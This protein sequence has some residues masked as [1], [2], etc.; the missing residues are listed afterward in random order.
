VNECPDVLTHSWARALDEC[1][2]S[3]VSLCSTQ[4]RP[5]GTVSMPVCE[6]TWEVHKMSSYASQWGGG[7]WP[8]PVLCHTGLKLGEK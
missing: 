7:R 5:G 8:V 1:V 3:W 6:H 2:P 4:H